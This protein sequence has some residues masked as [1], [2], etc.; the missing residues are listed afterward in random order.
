MDSIP[1]VLIDIIYDYFL[2]LYLLEHKDKFV[3]VM[4]ELKLHYFKI[5]RGLE[6]G[7]NINLSSHSLSLNHMS[8]CS[9]G[10]RIGRIRSNFEIPHIRQQHTPIPRKQFHNK[11][12]MRQYMKNLHFFNVK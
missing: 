12:R 2:D 3:T 9:Q 4:K 5:I 8:R 7:D 10:P 11:K 6:I 1:I